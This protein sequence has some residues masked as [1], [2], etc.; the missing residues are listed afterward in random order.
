M[1]PR[2][3]WKKIAGDIAQNQGRL[4]MMVAAIAAG[5]FALAAISTAYIILSRELDR[6]YLATNPATALLDVDH[7][8]AVAVAGARQQPGVAWAEA[9]GRISGRVEVRT[10]TWLPLLLFVVPD[11]TAL[12]IARVRL[13]AGQWPAGGDGIAL[14]R[15]ALS[16]ANTAYGGLMT[17]QT[18]NGVL[19][20]LRV[21][22]VVHDPSLAP[23]W[24]QQTVYGYVTPATLRLMGEDANLRV[25]K[26]TVSDPSADPARIEHIIVGVAKWLQHAGYPVGEIRIPPRHHPHREQMSS[27]TRMLLAF[28]ALT[29]LLG[30]ILTAT[31]TASLLAPQVRQIAVMKAI[32]ARTAQI[33]NLYLALIAAVGVVAVSLGLPLGIA[34]GRALALNVAHILNLDL[35]SLEVSPG[36][37]WAKRSQASGCRCFWRC[38]PSRA[39]PG[40]RYVSR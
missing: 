1:T 34:G 20:N 29:L 28:G 4:V 3:R 10:N 35:A 14:E 27:V 12:R 39:P 8:D 30:A 36:S 40:I 24:Q 19:R 17:V 9:G 23:A 2:P 25:L 26:V 18:R 5:T 32:G 37:T 16:V 7:L 15:T 6:S 38:S 21:V 13:E 31:L 11:F 33:M 22:G